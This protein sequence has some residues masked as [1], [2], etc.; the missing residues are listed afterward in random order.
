VS[1]GGSFPVNGMPFAFCAAG[2]LSELPWAKAKLGAATASAAIAIKDFSISSPV[3]I[4]R[5]PLFRPL[6]G[7]FCTPGRVGN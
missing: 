4:S 1:A 6:C 7:G 2:V 3:P 5:Y